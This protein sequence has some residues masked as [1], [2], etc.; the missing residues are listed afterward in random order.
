MKHAHNTLLH[1]NCYNITYINVLCNLICPG[2]TM[3]F[4][5]AN[6]FE[7]LAYIKKFRFLLL[8]ST[9]HIQMSKFVSK[10]DLVAKPGLL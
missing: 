8:I 2:K 1:E 6:A 5:L 3:L 7:F 9:D 4:E 10:C